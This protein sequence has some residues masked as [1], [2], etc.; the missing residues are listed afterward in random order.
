MKSV[1]STRK[2]RMDS[3]RETARFVRATAR[4]RAARTRGSVEASTTSISGRPWLRSQPGSISRSRVIS[5][6]MKGS[7][8][9]MTTTWETSGCPRS[10]SSRMAGATFLPP[11]VTMI[12][13]LRP[14][15]LIQP[16]ESI[17]PMSPVRNQPSGVKDCASAS[18]L[19]W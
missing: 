12:S 11:A 14:V 10:R 19:L 4:S 13:F 3:A 2:E 1:V 17:A 18:G 9:P 16:S 8:S 6:E 5:A 7:P 15:I